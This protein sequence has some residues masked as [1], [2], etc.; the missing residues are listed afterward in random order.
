MKDTKPLEDSNSSDETGALT[1]RRDAIKAVAAAVAAGGLT[2]LPTPAGAVAKRGSTSLEAR[3]TYLGG[4]TYLIEIG[5]FRII[6]DPGFDPQGTERNEGPGHLLT[7][8]MEPPIPVDQI[9]PIDLALVSHAQHLD[10]LDNEGRR[11]LTKVG[12]TLTT[13]ESA[14]NSLRGK[15]V[16]LPTWKS[17]EITNWPWRAPQDHIHA[18]GAYEQSGPAPDRW[19]GDGFHARVAG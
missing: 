10:N 9:G 13:P 7:K 19:R 5:R 11:L 1:S 18:G 17:Q 6:S 16:G 4:P 15:A 14:A 8:V 3:V 12:M 2:Q